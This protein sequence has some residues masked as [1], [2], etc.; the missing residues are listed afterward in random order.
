[1][2]AEEGEKILHIALPI[3]GGAI[4]GMD[5]PL[6]RG[7]VNVGNNFMISL[8][9]SSKEETVN[10]FSSLSAGGFVMMPLEDQFWGAYFGMFTDQFGI[11][12]MLSYVEAA[13]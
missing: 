5:M 4:A 10:L 1:M 13:K 3:G 9:T 12:W 6:G 7:T 2:P 8:D 11:Q